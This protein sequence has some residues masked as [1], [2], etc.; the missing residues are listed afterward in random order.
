MDGGTPNYPKKIVLTAWTVF[1]WVFRSP[2]MLMLLVGGFVGYN[3]GHRLGAASVMPRVVRAEQALLEYK[4]EIAQTI[5][6]SKDQE[7]RVLNAI[8][9]RFY[10]QQT[11]LE[12]TRRNLRNARNDVRLCES[13]STLSVSDPATG[14]DGASQNGQP[15]NADEVLSDLAAQIASTADEQGARCNALIEWVEGIQD[16]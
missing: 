9:A 7:V 1:I 15:R 2:T 11:E 14:V 10:E 6:K 13:T 5:A 8:R 3:M 4:T 12:I 16:Q